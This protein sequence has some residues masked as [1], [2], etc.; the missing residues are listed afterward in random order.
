MGDDSIRKIMI[1]IIIILLIALTSETNTSISDYNNVNK[2]FSSISREEPKKV[3]G[4]KGNYNKLLNIITWKGQNSVDFNKPILVAH[5][6]ASSIAPENSIPAIDE[7]AKRGY[8]GVEL[9]I[10][11]SSDGVLYLL[12]DGRLDRTTNGHGLITRKSSYK[13]NKLIINQGSNISS[14]PNLKL[15]RFEDALIECKK[16]KVVP[17]F[18][19]KFLS[20]SHRDLDTF[21][22][23]IHK[24]DYEKKLLVHAFNY[25]DLEYLRSKDKN[26]ILM[27]MVNPNSIIHG[28]N[29]IKSFGATEIDSN[30]I[31]LNK[32]IVQRAHKDGLKVFCWTVDTRPE[33]NKAL[34]LDVD[35]IY[36]DTFYPGNIKSSGK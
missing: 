8:W 26:I 3:P 34:N 1:N 22:R 17:V 13:V 12:H 7:A 20:K 30:I 16:Y 25:R 24:H 33:L 11:S 18:D 32:R 28:Y 23:I 27:P 2:Y 14:Y 31:Y 10:C 19:I 5:R 15:P 6:G 36:S 35:F 21:L 9:D 4:L 29:Y